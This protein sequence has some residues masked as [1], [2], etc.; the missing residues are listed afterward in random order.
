LL[1]DLGLP[2]EDG[3]GLIRQ[4]RALGHEKAIRL[5]AAAL[6][7]YGRDEDRERALQEGFDFHLAK[8]AEPSAIVETVAGLWQS[9]VDRRNLG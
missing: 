4:V 7:A 6:T 2:G 1:A 5:P 8:P 9:S 3:Y